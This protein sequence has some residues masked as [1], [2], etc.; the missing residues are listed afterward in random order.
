[1]SSKSITKRE[2]QSLIKEAKKHDKLYYVQAAP[3]ISDYEYDRLIKQIEAIEQD[4]PEW[5]T[6]D[7]PTQYV[8]TDKKSGFAQVEHSHPMLSLTNTYSESELS[9]FIK[10]MQKHL[11]RTEVHFNVELKMDGVA[12]ALKYEKGELVQAVTRGNGRKGDDV[13]ANARTITNLPK[14]LKGKNIPEVLE[15][16]GEVYMPLKVFQSLNQEKEE[17]GEVV[18]ANPRNAA[19]GS[20][21]LLDSEE[22][23]QR[24]LSIVIYDMV[25]EDSDIKLQSRVRDYLEKFG[26]PVFSKENTKRLNTAKEILAFAHTIEKQRSKYP[27]EIDGIVVKLDELPERKYIGHTGKSPRWAVAYKFAPEQAT[28]VIERIDIQVGRTGVLTPVAHLRPVKLA[29]STIARATLHNRDEIERKDIREGD[30]V[31]IEKGG[32]VIPKVVSVHINERP[33]G[34][35]KW[36]MPTAC[37][38]CSTPVQHVQ[39]EVAVR[40]PNVKECPAQNLRR[41]I[42]FAAKGAMDIDHLGIKVAEKL[43]QKGLVSTI[44]DIYRLGEE[45]LAELEGF[46]EKSTQNLLRSIEASKKVSLARFIFS[47]GIP[48]VGIQTAEILAEHARKIDEL[49][50]M[51]EVELVEIEGIGP[52]VAHSIRAF[53]KNRKHVE[54][55]RELLALGVEPKGPK[56]KQLDHIFAGKTFV[57]TGTLEN[58]TRT[59]AAALIKERGGKVTGSVSAKT[60]FVL[61]GDSPGSKYDKAKKLGIGIMDEKEF[62]R[63]L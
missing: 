17:A 30:S 24:K 15:L 29:G 28:T 47:L 13:T 9:D 45:D 4:H 46:K 19:A 63:K 34:S 49:I 32:D 42:F 50:K 39:G 6:K 56:K 12:M 7:S 3:V 1:M 58:R 18:Y 25:T 52:K 41:I 33:K 61:V 22:A 27:F 59:E 53:F 2:Y 44:S 21:K 55:I 35:R 8:P 60:D 48:F 62:E 54:E 23:K 36:T 16:R 38:S 10:R 11:E 20:L 51:E 14:K 31:I 37:P 43:V 5:I 57:L 26:L 40:C